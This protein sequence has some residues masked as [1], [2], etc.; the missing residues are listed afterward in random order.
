MSTGSKG[1]PGIAC[2]KINTKIEIKKKVKT[3]DSNLLIIYLIIY[4]TLA[5]TKWLLSTSTKP[6]SEW[7]FDTNLTSLR[8]KS[9]IFDWI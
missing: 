4:V 3:I 5:S 7:S 9:G 1:P 8:L 2:I 6:I